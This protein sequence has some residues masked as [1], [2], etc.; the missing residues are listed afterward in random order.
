MAN[1]RVLAELMAEAG[2][3]KSIQRTHRTEK[4]Q[5]Q[6]PNPHDS[7]HLSIMK[8]SNWGTSD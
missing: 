4:R 1:P 6:T 8:N 3:T 2:R 5:H 7:L